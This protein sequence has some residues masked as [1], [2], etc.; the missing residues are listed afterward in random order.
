VFMYTHAHCMMYTEGKK[1]IE[2]RQL[3]TEIAVRFIIYLHIVGDRCVFINPKSVEIDADGFPFGEYAHH[4][5]W[6]PYF[7]R[8][9]FTVTSTQS[10][11]ERTN[12]TKSLQLSANISRS[13][14]TA[15]T[16]E[17]LILHSTNI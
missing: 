1:I 2:K 14:R 16:H 10:T 7:T 11:G 5:R 15:T 12:S 17:D 13:S 4:Y 6:D 8:Q 3:R 9:R